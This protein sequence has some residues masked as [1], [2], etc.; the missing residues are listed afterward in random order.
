MGLLLA[1]VL[2]VSAQ[3]WSRPS[4]HQ[5]VCK[6]IDFYRTMQCDTQMTFWQRL[7]YAIAQ[8]HDSTIQV[9]DAR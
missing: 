6:F 2:V 8:T 5:P 1:L 3:A 9:C 7:V 4:V